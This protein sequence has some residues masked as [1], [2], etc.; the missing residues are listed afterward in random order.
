MIIIA[1]NLT[2]LMQHA[3][4][5]VSFGSLYALYA[6]GIALIF[7]VMRLINFAH[8][9][10]I[11]AGTFAMFL[12]KGV[13]LVGLVVSTVIV[14]IC[15]ALLVERIAF[16]PGR[17]AT[18][19]TL[20]VTSFAVSY[21]L[22]NLATLV[23]GST[24][25]ALNIAPVLLGGYFVGGVYV[26]KLALTTV[27]VTL[28]LLTL[29][30]VFL[31]R[32]SIGVQVRAASENFRMARLLG[33]SANRVIAVAFAVSGILASV[34]AFLIVVQ[35]GTTWPTVGVSPVLIAFVATVIGGMGSLLGAVLGG[36]LLGVTT[37]LVQVALPVNLQPLRD[38]IVFAGVLAF[39]LLRPQG[40][41]IS[42]SVGTR[43]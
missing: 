4:D 25:K 23:F 11:M 6:L 27:V 37:V 28:V 9:E 24:P 10:F 5:A 8:G 36:Y 32:T 3:V 12:L 33:V 31:R 26:G 22:Q 19:A 1:A 29:L 39:L 7:G 21:L 43:V 20:L 42:G 30:A 18:P 2:S 41:I 40:L 17:D 35:T 38:A 34:A 13:T 15:L 14:V 16:R